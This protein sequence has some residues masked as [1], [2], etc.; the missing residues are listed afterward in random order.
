MCKRKVGLLVA[1]IALCVAGVVSAQQPEGEVSSD[2]QEREYWEV[3]VLADLNGHYGSKEYNRHVH[4]AVDWITDE[5]QPDLV[6]SAGDMVAGQQL[7]LNYRGMWEV[8]H[9]VVTEP[10]TAAGIPLAVTPGNHDASE[11]PKYWEERVEFAG[12]WQV[13]RPRLNFVDD[14]FYPFHYAFQ[15]GPGLF[16]SLDGTGVGEL[17]DAQIRWIEQVLENNGELDVVV[18]YSH[19]PQYPVAHGREHEVFGDER[20]A[21]LKQEHGVDLMVTGHHHAYYPARRGETTLLHVQALGSGTRSLLGEAEPRRRNVAVFR[22]DETGI[23]EIDAYLSPEFDKTVD[24]GELPET[25]GEGDEK[26]WRY[27][28]GR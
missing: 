8:F 3:A 13:R 4:A 2:S 28:D 15:M 23:V 16:I 12:Q 6:I 19:V 11:T 7:G 27:E 17:D 21:A 18:M 22:F 1:A 24:L 25:L 5:L 26:L 14:R 10:L 20:L 9:R